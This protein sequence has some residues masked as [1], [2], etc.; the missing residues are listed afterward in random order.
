MSA[1]LVVCVGNVCR[2]PYI[3]AR[4]QREVTPAVRI[5]SA[6]VRALVGEPLDADIRQLLH[7]IHMDGSRFRGKQL[8]PE[9]V[10]QADLVLTVSRAIRSEVVQEHPQALAKTFAIADFADLA[11]HLR[12]ARPQLDPGLSVRDRVRLAAARRPLFPP[13]DAESADIHDP[14]RLGPRGSRVMQSEVE[15]ILPPIVWLLGAKDR[16]PSPDPHAD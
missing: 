13:R 3:K 5:G 10:E 12:T 1:V 11:D 8:T 4:L 16:P 14:Y 6:G 9:M 7:E 2:S 15:A